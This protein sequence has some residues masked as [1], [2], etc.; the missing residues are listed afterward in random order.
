[1]AVPD[2]CPDDLRPDDRPESRDELLDN[3][4]R[5]RAP[6]RRM[7]GTLLGLGT[8]TLR[9]R[10]AEI[11]RALAEVGASAVLAGPGA[12]QWRCDP[13]PLLLTETEFLN[14]ADRL[15]QRATVIERLLA[16][17]YGA[18]HL[19]A[20][21][22]L[23]PALLYPS[24]H[25]VRAC[26]GIAQKRH[27]TLYAADL[28][29]SADGAWRVLADRT[30]QPAGL[31]YV[32]E[33]RRVMAR[34]LPELFRNLDVAEVRPFFDAWAD[35][36][37]R[38]VPAGVQNPGLALLTPGH[39]D[40]RWFEH[41]TLARTLGLA[42]VEDGDLTV[43]D[44]A[45]WIKTLRGLQPVHVLMRRQ[46]G[47]HVDPLE[48]HSDRA[49]V[50]HGTPGLLQAMREGAVQVVNAPGAGYAE[51][52][53]LAAF[54]PD[55]AK[56]LLGED[57]AM[58]SM[59]V[60]W[61]GD[62]TAC[63]TVLAA[64]DTMIFRDALDGDAK[65]LVWAALT[66]TARA[67]LLAE[68]AQNPGGFIAFPRAAASAAPCTGEGDMLEPRGVILRIFLIADGDGWRP[69]PG[70]LVR[71]LHDD[72]IAGG[73]LPREAL[74]KDVW[75]LREE[76]DILGSV[77]NLGSQALLIR[78][79]AGDLP[80]RVADNFYWFGRYLERLDSAVRLLRALLA[81]LGRGAVLPHEMPEIAVLAACLA[82]ARIIDAELTTASGQAI[83]AQALHQSLTDDKG[84]VA[85]LIADVQEVTARLRDRLSGEMYHSVSQGLR[86]L[87]GARL[88]LRSAR[89]LS[90]G[91]APHGLLSDFC[92]RVLEFSATVSGYAAENMVRGGGRL[93]L[94]LGRRIERAQRIAIQ[95]RHALDQ[96]P[97]R[98]E[99]G[100]A[101]VLE[102]C[103]STI[104]YRA[105][106]LN[107]VQPAPVLDLVL[108]DDG[109]PRG[110][111]YQLTQARSLLAALGGGA[112]AELA[113]LLDPLLAETRSIVADLLAADDQAVTAALMH[114]RLRAIETQLAALSDAVT[115]RYFAMLPMQSTAHLTQDGLVFTP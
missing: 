109:N 9:E 55:I 76:G 90:Q 57:L 94:D 21:G 29:R 110:L 11:D 63:G 113:C 51:A 22:V 114:D 106:Y 79:T 52:P 99:A 1:M 25:Y 19:L 18:R 64:P 83:L 41:V 10:R 30:A 77:G 39:G 35:L 92:G 60:L 58:P 84:R 2:L 27:V 6:W 56:N 72:D 62:P 38:L 75:V 87:K 26:R 3:S 86:S 88:A 78:R 81:R 85:G 43:R 103:D 5:L 14:I 100:L 65:P 4:G 24:P 111:A 50:T 46:D 17:V 34:V 104:T 107:V 42:L 37:Q 12:A 69:L 97:E 71:V 102:L 67:A 15:A 66:D 89:Q 59:P 82:E 115:R 8:A 48:L 45:V 47:R 54:L 7:L 49:A 23:P 70:G 36:L 96:R 91:P 112:E 93:F 32:L 16:D 105:R 80:S 101:L 13:I 44:G 28:I 98:I 73:A 95:I 20:D 61:L 40:Q 68:I 53:V 33:N 31:A 74:S 108:S